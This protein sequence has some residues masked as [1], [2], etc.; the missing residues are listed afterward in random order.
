LA[1]QQLCAIASLTHLVEKKRTGGAEEQE[2][3]LES[4]ELMKEKLQKN[5]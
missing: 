2:Q 1:D 5:I 3:V 4:G